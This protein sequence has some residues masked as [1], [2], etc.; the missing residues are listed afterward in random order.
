MNEDAFAR[1]VAE[2]VKNKVPDS[3]RDYLRLPENWTHWQRALLVLIENLN[4][5]LDEL[6]DAEK[7]ATTRYKDF[8]DDGLKLL[9]EATVEYETRRKKVTRFKFHVENRLDEVTR[10]IAL[11]SDAV[12]ERLKTVDLFRRAIERHR[13][14]LDE[15]EMDVSLIDEALWAVLDGRWEFDDLNLNEL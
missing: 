11:D 4:G 5:Q 15:Y 12:D 13:E 10:M 7:T 3:Q 2:E 1:L 9:T 8:G 14:M 6:A